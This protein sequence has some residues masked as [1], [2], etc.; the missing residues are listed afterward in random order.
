MLGA[1]KTVKMLGMQSSLYKRIESLRAHELLI[2]SR[3]RWVMVYY[4]ASGMS[5]ASGFPLI[6]G[7]G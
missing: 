7:L 6:Q 5:T 1:I 2:A 4:N 3:L